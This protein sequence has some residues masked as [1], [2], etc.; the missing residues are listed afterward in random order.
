MQDAASS[1]R[2][3]LLAAFS[4]HHLLQL[5]DA[6]AEGRVA[7]HALCDALA[8]VD[9][10]CVVAPT[11]GHADARGRERGQLLRQVHRH[12]ASLH[13]RS[14]A[15]TRQDFLRIDLEVLARAFED[16]LCRQL[17]ALLPGLSDGAQDDL[18]C[19][20]EVDVACPHDGIGQQGVEHAFEVTHAGIDS[21]GDVGDHLLGN[22]QAV[23]ADLA[24]Q[25]VA[26]HFLAG[27]FQLSQQAPLEARQQPLLHALQGHGRTVAGQDELALVLMQ[28]VED[29]EECQLGLLQRGEL[30]HV[31][32]D[33]D[34]DAL[35]EGDEVVD[36]VLADGIGV[37]HLE[38]VGRHIEDALA[39]VQLFQSRAD[40]ID[41]VGLAATRRAIDKKRV[42]SHLLGV[43]GDGQS[44]GAREFVL[45]A[46]HE[47]IERVAGIQLRV[48][49]LKQL[50]ALVPVLGL[51][52]LT[53]GGAAVG[54]LDGFGLM[55]GGIDG[56]RP[57]QTYAL[58]VGTHEHRA[59][60]FK[61]MLLD[62]FDD[63][64]AGHTQGQLA[65][66]LVEL[67]EADGGKP[68]AKLL[69]R[70]VI[71]YQLQTK[72]PSVLDVHFLGFHSF[73]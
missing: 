35:I 16:K 50:R 47:V 27:A 38:Q 13:D 41:E 2:Q 62:V 14:L 54:G 32:D 45:G 15:R 56:D 64:G 11:D 10:R 17:R 33:Q 70:D 66:C 60:K 12:L 43:L 69:R 37:L 67:R 22:L 6:L 8:R 21:A 31:V 53:R 5:F 52:G 28:M 48:Q 63:E 24:A 20:L 71:T 40:G 65:E 19:Q 49:S 9:H 44:D 68:S 57:A 7:G 30:L 23:V 46:F 34:V 25:D 26:A 42:E 29:M 1:H 36:L 18:L 3:P 55:V 51:R 73:W 58:S 39:G 4:A 61:E 59:Q 72:T